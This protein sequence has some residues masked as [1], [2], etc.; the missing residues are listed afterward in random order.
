MPD[1]FIDLTRAAAAFPEISLANDRFAS[2]ARS[3]AGVAPEVNNPARLPPPPNLHLFVVRA[4]APEA[5]RE[6]APISPG[7]RSMS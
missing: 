4:A 2:M 6:T 1:L 5:F 7:A 3:R